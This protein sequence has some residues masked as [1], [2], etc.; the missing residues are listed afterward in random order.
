MPKTAEQGLDQRDSANRLVEFG[1][2]VEFELGDHLGGEVAG[3]DQLRLADDG[4]LIDV[5]A[6]DHVFVGVR[7]QKHVVAADH[8]DARLGLIFRRDHVDHGEREQCHDYGRAQDRVALA[9]ERCAE[10]RKIDIGVDELPAQRR[11]RR[12][13]RQTDVSRLLH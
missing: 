2:L 6:V 8:E 1:H 5:A 13:R 7:A 12:R 3:E 11:P 10:A 4:F 9:P